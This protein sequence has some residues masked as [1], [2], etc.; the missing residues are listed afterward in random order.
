MAVP[1]I[2]LGDAGQRRTTQLETT[3][4]VPVT[5]RCRNET[6]CFK[7]RGSTLIGFQKESPLK[8]WDCAP[9]CRSSH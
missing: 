8:L 9:K 4:L 5:L 3:S 6:C 2:L 7:Y 1:F